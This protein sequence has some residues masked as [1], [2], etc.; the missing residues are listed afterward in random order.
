MTEF[1]NTNLEENMED[2]TVV[3]TDDDGNEYVY[4]E[5]MKF[6]AEDGNIYAILVPVLPEH[7][8]EEGEEC[9]CDEEGVILAKVV[10]ADGEDE[11][12]EPTDM[13]FELAQKAYDQIMDQMEQAE[14]EQ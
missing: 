6:K 2:I 14:K 7:E 1:N 11:Y 13:E 4:L 3:F 12:L 5:E 8:H 10:S 9:L